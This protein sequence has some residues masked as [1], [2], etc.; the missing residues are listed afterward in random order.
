MSSA[1]P[2][3]FS[4]F[5]QSRLGTAVLDNPLNRTATLTYCGCTGNS[6]GPEGAMALAMAVQPVHDPVAGAWTFNPSLRSF[7]LEGKLS[8]VL[9]SCADEQ[10]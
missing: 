6:I 3:S 8:D 5:K 1:G 7:P 9:P 10:E 4:S 2:C